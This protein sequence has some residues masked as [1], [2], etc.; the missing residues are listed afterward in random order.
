[1]NASLRVALLAVTVTMLLGVSAVRGVAQADCSGQVYLYDAIGYGGERWCFPG[2]DTPYVGNDVNDR[3]SSV[4]NETTTPVEL[5]SE[6]DYAG[7]SVC[8]EP[9]TGFDD[10]S[11]V[12]LD[13]TISSIR[14]GSCTS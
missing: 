5:F 6:P 13:D 12:G 7:T 4:F 10:L 1:M 8:L 9:G 3:A 2:A 14:V 11:I